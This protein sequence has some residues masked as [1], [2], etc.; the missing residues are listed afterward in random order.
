MAPPTR[1]IDLHAGHIT[2]PAGQTVLPTRNI[3]LHAGHI[4]PPVGQTVLPT[5]N[6]EDEGGVGRLRLAAPADALG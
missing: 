3:D 4:A 2:L 6:I 1:N 5:R